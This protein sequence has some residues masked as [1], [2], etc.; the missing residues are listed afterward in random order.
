MA[1]LVFEAAYFTQANATL[2]QS[3]VNLGA[4][5]SGGASYYVFA[6]ENNVARFADS[7][8]S[9]VGTVTAYD[10]SGKEIPGESFYGEITRPSKV[11]NTDVYLQMYVFPDGVNHSNVN[12]ATPAKTILLDIKSQPLLLRAVSYLSE[13]R[14]IPESALA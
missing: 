5:V 9:V 1:R 2:Q 11:G 3:S 12:N 14:G 4:P 8:N 13:S 7:S 6:D 10:S